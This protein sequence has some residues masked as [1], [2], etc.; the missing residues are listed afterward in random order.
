MQNTC[1]GHNF[2]LYLHNNPKKSDVMMS[3]FAIAICCYSESVQKSNKKFNII[4]TGKELCIVL[5][6]QVS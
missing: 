2:L 5:T 4:K 6:L 3:P 1:T